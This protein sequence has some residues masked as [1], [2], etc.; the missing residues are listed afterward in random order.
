MPKDAGTYDLLDDVGFLLSR[1]SGVAVR[2]A[3]ECLA[4]LG[5][6]ARSFSVLALVVSREAM[7]QRELSDVLG[8]DP[9]Q[10]V[11]LVDDLEGQG[12]I[13]RRPGRTDRR[14]R[15]LSSTGAGLARMKAAVRLLT[16]A[17]RAFLGDLTAN[18]RHVLR[19]LLR[20]VAFPATEEAEAVS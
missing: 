19:E 13:E 6:R 17:Q 15:V 7:S 20:R 3:N 18:E 10:V 12:L 9:S 4:P 11:A 8:L 1:S 16:E 14:V 5:L 2:T